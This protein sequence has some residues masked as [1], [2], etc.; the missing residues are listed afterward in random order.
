[1]TFAVVG[2]G[3]IGGLLGARLAL[4]GEK[5]TFV[6]RGA[7][8]EAIR[9]KG[10][11][12]IEEDG[13]ERKVAC[14]AAAIGEAGPHDF[15]LL[16]LKAHQ[17]TAIAKDLPRL[18]HAG[19]AAVTFQNG[20][21]WWYFHKLEGPFEGRSVTAADPDGQVAANIGAERVIGAVV[22]PAS[23]LIAPGVVKVVEGN[24]FT[25]GEPDGSKSERVQRLSEAL[26]KAGFRAPIS[27]DIRTEIWLK[28]WGNAT[29]NPISA[30]TH[31]TL[32]DIC[33]YPE[34]RALAHAVMTEAQA[35][36]EKLG[37]RSRIGIDKRIAG[38]EAVGAHKTS[39]LQDV[40]AGRAL[41]LEALAGSV[42]EL[43]RLTGT[44]TPHLDT[45]YACARL[46]AKTL[47]EQKGKLRIQPA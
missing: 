2:A 20:L 46:L 39:M 41:E 25:I 47:G 28:L 23:E 1:M 31:A 26:I 24:R 33:Q 29:F 8:L 10:F 43:A 35:V 34:T 9:R 3:A 17:V 14:G 5:V 42:I 13:T 36:A 37:V 21:P 27:T 38:A 11:T 7:N 18:F 44:P 45:I 12:L 15:V 22:Y 4:A 30:L 19:T 6:A 40:E 32:V 16:A